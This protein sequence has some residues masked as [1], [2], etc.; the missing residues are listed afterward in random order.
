MIE[1]PTS[2]VVDFDFWLLE[3]YRQDEGLW[4][5]STKI[6]RVFQSEYIQPLIESLDRVYFANLG[7]QKKC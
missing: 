4:M 6:F 3:L 7:I 2:I 1:L 5:N